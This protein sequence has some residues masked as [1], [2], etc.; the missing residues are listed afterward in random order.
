MRGRLHQNTK[1]TELAQKT[2]SETLAKE[3][4]KRDRQLE[5][6]TAK[7]KELTGKLSE[8]EAAKQKEE[9]RKQM[10][11]DFSLQYPNFAKLEDI[12]KEVLDAV[13]NGG[14]NPIQAMRAYEYKQLQANNKALLEKIANLE[15]NQKN[16]QTTVGSQKD[17]QSKTGEPDIGMKVFFG[18]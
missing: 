1:A 9:Q 8:A 13:L 11:S 2:D 15:R 7:E 14:E 17:T 18:S 16:K 5:Q 4:L 6:Y 3:V 10:W 12:P